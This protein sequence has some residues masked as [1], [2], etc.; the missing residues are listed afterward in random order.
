VRVLSGSRAGKQHADDDRQEY[1]S[2]FLGVAEQETR[3]NVKTRGRPRQLLTDSCDALLRLLSALCS[4]LP[5]SISQLHGFI[6]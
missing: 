6:R 2:H 1:L 4:L 3:R 5:A